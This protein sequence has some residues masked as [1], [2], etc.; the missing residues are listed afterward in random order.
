MFPD[1]NPTSRGE[2]NVCCPFHND[3]SPSFSINIESGMFICRS[4]SCGLKGGFPYFYK[5]MENIES[6]T[7]VYKEISQ[8]SSDFDISDIFK[9]KKKKEKIDVGFPPDWMVEPIVSL[10]YLSS[11]NLGSDIIQNFGLLYGK[12]G[13]YGKVHVSGSI[14]VPVWDI[15]GSYKT[16]QVRYLNEKARPRWSGPLGSPISDCLYGGWLASERDDE[17]WIVEGASDVWN[18]SNFG[19]RAVGLST[20]EASASQ[21]LKIHQL[22]SSYDLLPII[23]LDGDVPI[24]SMKAK[25]D[26]IGE[27]FFEL[28]AL[29]LSPEVVILNPEEDPG[30]ISYERYAEIRSSIKKKS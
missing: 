7:D 15:D 25:R 2:I 8:T 23:C 28:S 9:E 30:N 3:S 6:W 16:F 13:E 10:E 1:G 18:M 14:I 22:C 4:A 17:L 20:K 11:R 12:T 21:L 29:S 27:L 24:L 5:L 26:F 19:A